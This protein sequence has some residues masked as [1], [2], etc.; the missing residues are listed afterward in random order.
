MVLLVF[1]RRVGRRLVL[2]REEFCFEHVK[3]GAM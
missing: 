3:D 2:E 1:W